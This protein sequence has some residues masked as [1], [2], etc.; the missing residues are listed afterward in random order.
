MFPHPEFHPGILTSIL[1][2]YAPDTIHQSTVIQPGQLLFPHDTLHMPHVLFDSGALQ[3]N[4]IDETFVDS[5]PLLFSS[6]TTHLNHTVR[7][8]DN[9]TVI[10]LNRTV[11]VTA[12]FT[13]NTKKVHTATIDCSVLDMPGTQMIIG[14]PSI[15]FTFY[16]FFVDLLQQARVNLKIKKRLPSTT[17]HSSDLFSDCVHPWS[18]PPDVEAIEDLETPE[19][20]SFTGPL[21]FLNSTHSDSVLE[22][23]N[24]FEKHIAPEFIQAVP[25]IIQYLKSDLVKSIFVPTTWTG[26]NNIDPIELEFTDTLPKTLRPKAR[27]INPKLTE[28]AK[29]EFDRLCQHFYEPSTSSIASCLV[30]APKATKPFI[31][32]CGDY[33]KINTHIHIPHYPIP[34]VQTALHKALGY[35]IYMDLD[36]RNSFHQ[37]PLGP[38]TS[39]NL[40]IQTPW[41]LVKPKFVPEGVGPASGILQN[42]IM[43]L[44]SDFDE[45]TIAIFDNLL[46]LAHD[47]ADAFTK[48]KIIFTRCYERNVILT[49]SKTWLAFPSVSFFGYLI[50]H[51]T[52]EMSADRKDSILTFE[53]PHNVKSMQRFLGSALFFKGFLPN[54]SDLTSNLNDMT[55][56]KFD[57]NQKSWTK[58]YL[59]DFNSFKTHLLSSVALYFPDYTLPWILRTDAS[60]V[61][62]AAVLVQITPDNIQQPLAFLSSK[63]SAAAKNWAINKKE[64]FAIYNAVNLLSYL[65]R[66]RSFIIETDHANLLYLEQ[67]ATPILTRWR[68][69]LQSFNIKLKHIAGKTNT[70]ADWLSRQYSHSASASTSLSLSTATSASS[71]SSLTTPTV[72]TTTTPVKSNSTYTPE[73]LF[74]Q[75]HGDRRGHHGA[76]RTWTALNTEFPGHNIPFSTIS[77]LIAS[78]PTCQKIRI[79][80]TSDIKPLILHNKP[81]HIRTRIGVDTLTVT[82]A[83]KKGNY[84]I[85]VIVEHFTKYTT[86][87]PVS[88]HTAETMASSLFQHFCKFG[89]Y[90]QLISDPG[91][92][93]MSNTVTLL[94]QYFGIQKLVSLVDRH[95]SN[96]VEPTNK[97]ILRHLSALVHDERNSSSW[98]DPTV[99][100]LI[101]HFLNS[102]IHSETGLSPLEA[103]FGSSAI[104]YFN[105]PAST[106]PANIASSPFLTRL[107]NHLQNIRTISHE[108]QQNLASERTNTHLPQNTFQPNDL[109]LFQRSTTHEVPSKLSPKFLGP[110]SVIHQIKND[111]TCRNLITD[112]LSV[113]HVTRLKLFIGTHDI[114]YQHAL[115]DNNQYE[116]SKIT[117]YRGDPLKRTS[118]EFEVLFTDNTSSWKLWD[119]D[120]F[121]TIQYEDFCRSKSELFPLIYTLKDSLSQIK[122]IRSTPISTISP[123][124]IIYLDLRSYGSAWYSSLPI[125]DPDHLT[126]VVALEY[127]TWTHPSHLKINGYVPV[128]NERWHGKSSLD[129]YFVHAWGHNKILTPAMILITPAFLVKYPSVLPS[130]Q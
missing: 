94:N 126:Y 46:V 108:Y 66:T 50:K 52:Y 51:N 82:P 80:M 14:L 125:P 7:L 127:T 61:A 45:W 75:V 97:Q 57:W 116:I 38:K 113:F 79:G 93:L 130:P 53:M 44:F 17:L 22:Y 88:D 1:H 110:Y 28:H 16:D 32:F 89:I 106:T 92:D 20:C 34:H 87:Y 123:L 100:P 69:F 25:E 107:N 117:A 67:N 12:S 96:G 124:D 78:C 121:T 13:D 31:R 11:R 91:S 118:V 40:S 122:I 26:I 33:V 2:A 55:K 76:K 19:P 23:Y 128:F 3:S 109:V 99:L 8:G 62:S 98:S 71:P 68:I 9:Q 115:R 37:I 81:P 4:Y 27:N 60:D 59:K 65:L 84:L 112:A 47:Y 83:D 64:A 85:I 120:L 103:K 102:A 24:Q 105:F 70:V 74:K 35:K 39:N 48:L 86:L 119:N 36:L 6:I 73:H 21:D 18:T 56:D 95:E 72:A 101:E 15:L 114:A 29:K 42:L 129:S 41:G 111:V 30:V 43:S 104:P 54:Y 49:F 5:H 58:D 63:F 77:D 90:D 10:P